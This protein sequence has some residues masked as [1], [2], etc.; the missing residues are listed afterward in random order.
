[1]ALSDD[2]G[3]IMRAR[4]AIILLGER[5]GLSSADSLG[6]YLTWGPEP[7]RTDADRNCVSNIRPNG[8]LSYEVAT[9]KLLYLALE[10]A[11]R[12]LSG[13]NLKDGSDQVDLL[14]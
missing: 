8:G 13:V 1:V 14:T 12:Q 4:A 9:H 5:P 10:S 3:G 6:A 11:R 7:G 2:I